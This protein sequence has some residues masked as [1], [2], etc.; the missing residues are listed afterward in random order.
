V[1]LADRI[2]EDRVG[3]EDVKARPSQARIVLHRLAHHLDQLVEDALV[4]V[5]KLR[6]EDGVQLLGEHLIGQPAAVLRVEVGRRAERIELGDPALPKPQR[7]QRV[8]LVP[9]R[10]GLGGAEHIDLDRLH[11]SP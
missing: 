6:L 8:D 1:D 9:R 7:T 4:Y 10:L 5:A 3:Q 2:L 11:R